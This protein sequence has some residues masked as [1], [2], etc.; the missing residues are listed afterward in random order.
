MN[1]KIYFYICKDILDLSTAQNT[2][3]QLNM[4]MHASLI[5]SMY[6]FQM[7]RSIYFWMTKC[8]FMSGQGSC[9]LSVDRVSETSC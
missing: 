1:N 8:A 2:S 4:G 7:G 3:K 6:C 9:V 5:V